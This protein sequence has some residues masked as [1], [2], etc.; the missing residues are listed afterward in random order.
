MLVVSKASPHFKSSEKQAIVDPIVLK[1]FVMLLLKQSL[2]LFGELK[3]L[4]LKSCAVVSRIND[5]KRTILPL[6]EG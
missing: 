5:V 4:D 1:F 3:R 6:L 2:W